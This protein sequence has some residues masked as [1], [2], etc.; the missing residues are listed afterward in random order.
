MSNGIYPSYQMTLG[1]PNISRGGTEDSNEQL[2][3]LLMQVMMLQQQ[4]G[5]GPR[6]SRF[7]EQ[8]EPPPPPPESPSG[9]DAAGNIL[10]TGLSTALT[11][12]PVV[13]PL[14][15]PL[16]E[17]VA[18][19]ATG[20]S[21]EQTLQSLL[22]GV[23]NSAGAGMGQMRQQDF[24]NDLLAKIAGFG[25]GKEGNFFTD[26]YNMPGLD[27]KGQAALGQEAREAGVEF[28][29]FHG[30]FED[31]RHLV[32]GED[33]TISVQDFV[34][35]HANMTDAQWSQAWIDEGEEKT[36]DL[37]MSGL[38]P[39]REK[40]AARAEK[41]EMPPVK[42]EMDAKFEALQKR[43]AEARERADVAAIHPGTEIGGGPLVEPGFQF[44][45][46]LAENLKEMER[47]DRATATREA[48]GTWINWDLDDPIAS[49]AEFLRDWNKDQALYPH[50]DSR[51]RVVA[52]LGSREG[53]DFSHELPSAQ[54]G[55][56]PP[57]DP[58]SE[59]YGDPTVY[60]PL[61]PGRR[62]ETQAKAALLPGSSF[63]ERID[64]LNSTKETVYGQAAE[65][66]MWARPE[67]EQ[68]YSDEDGNWHF[69]D[70]Y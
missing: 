5:T 67:K 49:H 33:G 35:D 23:A 53:K 20:A 59:A 55:D 61:K 9:W 63:K 43:A 51:R 29:S 12:I 31:N 65:A 41:T 30:M 47:R 48:P 34:P 10:K 56:F 21:G 54:P 66:E 6:D 64:Q 70:D 58:G 13:G 46:D 19:A 22:G 62:K 40:A 42:S 24:Q 26:V 14:I 52:P 1:G 68:G 50:T 37:F 28:P 32:K 3:E 7:I 45:G 4:T 11:A 25:G 38:A 36:L 2:R 16:V 18:D 17:P 57:G 8:K 44:E 39:V 15:A 69:W 27:M 60:D